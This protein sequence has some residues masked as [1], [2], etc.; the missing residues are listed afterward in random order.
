MCVC[1]F[2]VRMMEKWERYTQL[3]SHHL[4]IIKFSFLQSVI[5]MNSYNKDNEN[6]IYKNLPKELFLLL[7][8][9]GSVL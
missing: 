4:K 8:W 6:L 3:I 9:F 5:C 2:V 7:V 1:G